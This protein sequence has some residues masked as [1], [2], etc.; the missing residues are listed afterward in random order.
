LNIDHIEPSL[1][2]W[3]QLSIKLTTK[4]I[5]VYVIYTYRVDCKTASIR[6]SS[7]V[8]YTEDNQPMENTKDYWGATRSIAPRLYEKACAVEGR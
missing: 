2:G 5:G 3:P 6:Q 8:T 7:E 1:S 4:N